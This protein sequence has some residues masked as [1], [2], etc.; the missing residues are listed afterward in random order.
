MATSFSFLIPPVVA[1]ASQ[2]AP[3]SILELGCGIG[4]YGLL[5]GSYV[6]L[7][8]YADLDAAGK[9]LREVS[10]VRIDAV[11]LN[12]K[13][14]MPHHG[15]FYSS[16]ILADLEQLRPEDLGS[17][18]LILAV[19]VVEHL[20]KEPALRLLEALYRD[21]CKHLLV[22]SPLGWMEQGALF[23]S[24]QEVHRISWTPRDFRFATDLTW[25]RLYQSGVYL[26]SHEPVDVPG[27]GRGLTKR[28][29]RLA[30][31]LLNEL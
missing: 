2:L 30:R 7:D 12:Q 8:P 11:E 17:Y 16:I 31:N 9:P 10:H 5:L 19:D 6:G 20:R 26:L 29:R 28:L 1:I 27:F 24:E 22:T 15:E 23:G 21:H 4:K 18:D 13:Y 14:L 3:K 25:Q